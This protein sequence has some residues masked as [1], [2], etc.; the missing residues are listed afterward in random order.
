MK[1]VN[2]E[3]GERIAKVRT[4]RKYSREYLAEAAGISTKFL[5]EIEVGKK[6]CSA[7]ILLHICDALEV[8]YGYILTG[9]VR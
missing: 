8:D 7:S 6:E 1:T 5:Y 4:I 9:T 3:I 2:K